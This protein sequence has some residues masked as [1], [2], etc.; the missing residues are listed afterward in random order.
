MFWWVVL[1]VIVAGFAV[2]WWSSGRAHGAKQL[3]DEH[4]RWKGEGEAQY[5]G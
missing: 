3:G 2:A 4:A 1:A 5:R